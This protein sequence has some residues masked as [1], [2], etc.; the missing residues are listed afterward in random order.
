MGS[1]FGT[2]IRTFTVTS[3]ILDNSPTYST[4]VKWRQEARKLNLADPDFQ[5]GIA[6]LEQLLASLTSK[7]TV[8]LP[9]FPNP[10]NPKTWIPGLFSF[11]NY[12]Y[13]CVTQS[14]SCSWICE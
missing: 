4:V 7:E 1:C 6:V 14:L 8:L 10:F 5:R 11:M 12:L 9:N 3:F 2:Y 13:M